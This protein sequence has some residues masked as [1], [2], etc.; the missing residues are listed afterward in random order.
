MVGASSNRQ[1]D[2]AAVPTNVSVSMLALPRI[3][4]LCINQQLWARHAASRGS[5][6]W[7]GVPTGRWGPTLLLATTTTTNNQHAHHV[8][9]VVP[10]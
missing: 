1:R 4:L 8:K 3:V 10:S 9:L 5:V 7:E 6:G 2:H